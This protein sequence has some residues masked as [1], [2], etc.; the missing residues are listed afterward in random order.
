[1]RLR[2]SKHKE[3]QMNILSNQRD[4]HE[5]SKYYMAS[6][7]SHRISVILRVYTAITLPLHKLWDIFQV[8]EHILLFLLELELA[9][10]Y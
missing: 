9:T 10:K 6:N 2:V 3:S 8:Y 7:V 1:M 5:I 4:S